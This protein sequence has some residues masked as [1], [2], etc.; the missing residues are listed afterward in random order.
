MAAIFNSAILNSA[1]LESANFAPNS[2]SNYLNLTQTQS[3]SL[4]LDDGS[5]LQFWPSWIQPS[6]NQPI[7]TKLR[8]KLFQFDSNSIIL[9]PTWWWFS[10]L[11][12][13]TSWTYCTCSLH[14]FCI[15]LWHKL[16]QP[17]SNA[18]ILTQL[19]DGSRPEFYHVEFRHCHLGFRHLL[20]L[21]SD[22]FK[23]TLTCH[24]DSESK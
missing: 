24:S 23:N 14:P 11:E 9:M 3:F 10:H 8:L 22:S 20:S 16:I 2:D 13:C 18:F 7:F 19:D 6:W 1:M 21:V 12:F 15:K 4:Q 5:L 17:D